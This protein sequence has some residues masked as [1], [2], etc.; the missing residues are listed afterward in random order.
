MQVPWALVK[1][2]RQSQAGAPAVP[3]RLLAVGIGS[4]RIQATGTGRAV[5]GGR[6]TV[7]S[8]TAASWDGEDWSWVG[9]GL[10]WAVHACM[11]R[12]AA[13]TTACAR[14]SVVTTRPFAPL[15]TLPVRHA[16]AACILSAPLRVANRCIVNEAAAASLWLL[17]HG[18]AQRRWLAGLVTQ[19]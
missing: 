2:I 10:C 9:S 4:S 16:A 19:L 3:V 8:A 14:C 15:R 12:G 1:A 13:T 17:R 11:Q 18:T 6:T 5:A 7:R